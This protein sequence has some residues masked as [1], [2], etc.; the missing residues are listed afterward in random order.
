MLGKRL[1]GLVELRVIQDGHQMA[2]QK[3]NSQ[4]HLSL[5]GLKYC[6]YT[7]T[8]TGTYRIRKNVRIQT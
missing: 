1:L 5:P 6:F 3:T 2:E 8:S 7:L 4:Y